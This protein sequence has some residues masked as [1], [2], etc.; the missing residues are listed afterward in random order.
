MKRF[1]ELGIMPEVC[2]WYSCGTDGV[3]LI[4]DFNNS[5]SSM[6]E[7]ASDTMLSSADIDS[8]FSGGGFSGF[9]GAG[10]GGGAW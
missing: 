3:F 7:S 8:G 4:S 10:G 6:M 2:E 5:F 1:E 9:G